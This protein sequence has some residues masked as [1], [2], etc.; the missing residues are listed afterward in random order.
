MEIS[1][2]WA[3]VTYIQFLS[4]VINISFVSAPTKK[5]A[6]KQYVITKS[7]HTIIVHKQQFRCFRSNSWPCRFIIIV[8]YATQ[9][10]HR[11]QT[12]KC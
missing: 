3:F 11:I 4:F 6:S 7:N 10:A 2:L 9:A 1:Y 8:Y 5:P 12:E